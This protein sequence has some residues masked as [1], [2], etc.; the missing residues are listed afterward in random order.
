MLFRGIREAVGF[1]R[2]FPRYDPRGIF[3]AG[4][5]G[6]GSTFMYQVAME[7]GL[8]VHRKKHGKRP[9]E[10]GDFTVFAFRDPRDVLCSHARRKHRDTWDSDG[11]HA[12]IMQSLEQF[13]RKRY[14]EVIYESA[15][16]RNVFLARYELFCRGNEGLF[17]DFLADN[18]LVALTPERRAEILRLTSIESNVRRAQQ[19]DSFKQHDEKTQI[20]GG[21]VSN[22][23]RSGAWMESFTP[24]TVD[25]VKEELGALIIDLGYEQDL[26]WSC[27]PG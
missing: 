18:F 26:S 6:S 23:G 20:H 14:R 21:H 3:I 8:N 17:V 9:R 5:P 15:A 25:R 10:Y 7:L 12:A 1:R 27:E 13:L 16:M 24:A 2:W 11:P 19:F 4:W 22:K